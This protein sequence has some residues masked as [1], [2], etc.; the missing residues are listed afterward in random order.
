VLTLFTIPKPFNGQ[1]AVTQRNALKSWTRLAPYAEVIVF[2]EEEGTAEV[3][4]ELGLR[5]QRQIERNEFGTP[6]LNDAF[7]RA[8]RL[9]R[10]EW[11]CYANCDIVLT[12]DFMQAFSR[13][14]AWRLQWLMVGERWNTDVGGPLDFQAG[15]EAAL[16]QR[17]TALGRRPARD[18]IDYFVFSR[19][20]F[21]GFPPF[22]VGRPCWDLW[23]I[24]WM[25]H[26][27]VPVVDV[28][29]VMM[30]IHQNHDYS[31]LPE[32]PQS[33]RQ[34]Q[35]VSGNRA[36]VASWR[37]MYTLDDASHVLDTGGVHR[38]YT[39]WPVQTR[40]ELNNLRNRVAVATGPTRRCLGLRKATLS[41]LLGAR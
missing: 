36:L 5:H 23:T 22:A 3:C 2:G 7:N 39:H 37:H 34:G 41:R 27:R 33:V 9:A 8:Q 17:A 31:H 16:H 32:G 29:P 4:H 26:R 14:K 18:A 21:A 1:I 38:T 25:R 35:E 19:G 15:W 24:W 40:R 12:S 6:Y 11:L 13:V 20:L 10:H 28:S 30:A